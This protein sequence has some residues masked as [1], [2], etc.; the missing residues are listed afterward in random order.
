MDAVGCE[1]F[2]WDHAL[3]KTGAIV[4]Y[5]IVIL[6]AFANIVGVHN[7]QPTDG[8]KAGMSQ[9]TDIGKGSDQHADIAIERRHSSDRLRSI[10]V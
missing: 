2:G 9:P 3:V 6:Q 1:V 8:L 7:R 5:V 4:G 10:G